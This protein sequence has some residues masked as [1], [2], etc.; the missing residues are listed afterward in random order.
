M[1]VGG[2]M[3]GRDHEE[4]TRPG[5][6][7]ARGGRGL[8]GGGA[9]GKWAGPGASS[10]SGTS[11]NKGRRSRS[12][13]PLRGTRSS[14]SVRRH[15][16]GRPRSA[17]LPPVGFGA[18]GCGAPPKCRASA[19][20][21]QVVTGQGRG[22]RVPEGEAKQERA[23]A[24]QEAA[25]RRGGCEWPEHGGHCGPRHVPVDAGASAKREEPSTWR[26][27]G[28]GAS[29]A[30]AEG[31]SPPHTPYSRGLLPCPASA[32]ASLLRAL[33]PHRHLSCCCLRGRL[34]LVGSRLHVHRPHSTLGRDHSASS[35]AKCVRPC[36]CV[37]M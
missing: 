25:S 9:R 10:P 30:D 13:T 14:G 21:Q 17:A 16:R 2:T 34:M 18:R 22:L 5:V 27:E 1:I 3:C 23:H 24:P 11:G 4:V 28:P 29:R 35:V 15:P 7:G 37:H 8:R 20:P 6:G 31:R 33:G 36:A 32:E 19:A 26:P 12:R